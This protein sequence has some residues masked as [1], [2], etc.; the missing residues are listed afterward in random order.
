MGCTSTPLLSQVKQNMVLIVL[1]WGSPW[2]F[3]AVYTGSK[4]NAT[5]RASEQCCVSP[6]G[7]ISCWCLSEAHNSKIDRTNLRP[8]V[9][10]KQ[11]RKTTCIAIYWF[12]GEL[13]FRPSAQLESPTGNQ[14]NKLSI[15][16]HKGWEFQQMHLTQ[17]E[18]WWQR[19]VNFTFALF[20]YYLSGL[21]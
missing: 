19:I 14:L 16:H 1:A 10:Y 7:C 21:R 18:A 12:G 6:D 15:Q 9:C 8:V 11:G 17:D 5:K 20:I 2:N 3:G 13:Y 4:I